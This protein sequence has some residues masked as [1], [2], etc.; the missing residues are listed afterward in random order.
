MHL[1]V[2]QVEKNPAPGLYNTILILYTCMIYIFGSLC[3]TKSKGSAYVSLGEQSGKI[4]VALLLKKKV[5]LKNISTLFIILQYLRKV[6]CDAG[7]IYTWLEKL[8]IVGS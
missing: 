4:L 1:Y 3:N 8:G 5:S 6:T 7:K 2:Y